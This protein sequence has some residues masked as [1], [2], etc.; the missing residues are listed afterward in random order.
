MAEPGVIVHRDRARQ[1]IDFS[2]LRFG[3]NI[4]PTDIDGLI[5]YQN[6]AWI[7]IELKLQEAQCSGGQRLAYVRLCQDLQSTGK[8]TI[9]IIASHAVEDTTQDIDAAST[10][11]KEFYYLGKWHTPRETINLKGAIDKFLDSLIPF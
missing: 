7:W 10:T 6:S 8:P 3:A 2:G 4:T 5:E 9:F 1:I 11:V